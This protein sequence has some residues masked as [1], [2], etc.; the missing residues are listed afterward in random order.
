VPLPTNNHVNEP[1]ITAVTEA[2]DDWVFLATKKSKN[3]LLHWDHACSSV[4]AIDSKNRVTFPSL[5]EAES[6]GFRLHCINCRGLPPGAK[7]GP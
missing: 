6:Q 2:K 1:V 5:E 7:S 4:R 3:K